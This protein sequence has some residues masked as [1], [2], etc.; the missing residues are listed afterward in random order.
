MQNKY[1]KY[2][3]AIIE[4]RKIHPVIIGYYEIHHIRPK[5]LGGTDKQD[6]L[7]NLTGREHLVVHQLLKKIM[8]FKYGPDSN[9]YKSMTYA[10]WQMTNRCN[11]KAHMTSRQYEL[12]R[13][14]F[15]QM[16]HI[17]FSG[18]NNPRF[19][20]DVELNTRK[21]I[22]IANKGKI[23]WMKGKSHTEETKKRMHENHADVSG[24]NNPMYKTS[25]LNFM[26]QDEIKQ[27]KEKGRQSRLGRKWMHKYIG[28]ELIQVFA[29]PSQIKALLDNGYLLGR[30]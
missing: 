5:S 4:Y 14:E 22:S 17:R 18:K 30:K 26:T 24:K 20:K 25:P 1:E 13:K 29:K 21:K 9:E 16:Q 11:L 19:G 8:F 2:Y 3:N 10:L 6:N 12:L 23:P 28:T 15:S 7:V 27:W